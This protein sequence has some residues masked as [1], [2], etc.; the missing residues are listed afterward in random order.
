[1]KLTER[2]FFFPAVALCAAITVL[3]GGIVIAS[4]SPRPAPTLAVVGSGSTAGE[5]SDL[6]DAAIALPTAPAIEPIDSVA[7]I[8]D[9]ADVS[10]DTGN[11]ATIAADAAPIA[12]PFAFEQVINKAQALS[13]HAYQKSPS[14]PAA[15]ASLDYDQYRRIEFKREAAEWT[16]DDAVPYRV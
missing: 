3:L 5:T 10:G 4:I 2:P 15:A 9:E 7:D 16:P 13:E 8:S 1:M 14:V 12:P 6:T 11:P